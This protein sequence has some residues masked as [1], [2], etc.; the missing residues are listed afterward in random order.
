M[1]NK[2]IELLKN[3]SKS[4]FEIKDIGS[5]GDYIEAVWR[6]FLLLFLIIVTIAGIAVVTVGP[7]LF[8]KWAWKKISTKYIDEINR[9]WEDKSIESAKKMKEMAKKLNRIKIGYI[10]T[11]TILHTPFIIPL[12]LMLIDFIL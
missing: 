4:V 2:Y 8:W 1:L 3:L 5:L 11:L 12:I 6:G 7:F 9:L 10:V